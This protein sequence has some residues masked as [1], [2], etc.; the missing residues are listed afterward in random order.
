[1]LSKPDAGF[2]SQHQSN[3]DQTSMLSVPALKE[4][5]LDWEGETVPD[6]QE[7]LPPR[8]TVDSSSIKL[9]AVVQKK[10]KCL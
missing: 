5:L 7:L 6:F 8:G 3:D 2:K 9:W 10:I 1:M 4:A